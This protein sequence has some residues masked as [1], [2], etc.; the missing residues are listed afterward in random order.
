MKKIMCLLC[1]TMF[2]TCLGCGSETAATTTKKE[3]TVKTTSTAAAKDSKISDDLY[4]FEATINGKQYKIP[5]DFADFQKN[6]W[7]LDDSDNQKIEPDKY[8]LGSTLK[9]G[10]STLNVQFYNISKDTVTADKC[11]VSGILIESSDIDNG[12]KFQLPKGITNSSTKDDVIKAYG[13]PSSEEAADCEYKINEN[14]YVKF[15]F[16]D[17]KKI[18]E[19]DIVNMTIGDDNSKSDS[20]S[21]SSS[22]DSKD[23]GTSNYNAPKELGDNILSKNIKL[24]GKVYNLPVPV[25]VLEKD[26]WKLEDNGTKTL[27]SKDRQGGFDLSKGNISLSGVDLRNDSDKSTDAENCVLVGVRFDDQNGSSLELPK[28]IKIGS[29]KDEVEKAY[30]G[31]KCEKEEED[32]YT[33][34][35]YNFDDTKLNYVQ[36]NVDKSSNKVDSIEIT[37]I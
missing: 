22:N 7:K 26:G 34:Y 18:F 24:D 2:V 8:T 36:I 21:D 6:G 27:E 12:L 29:T 11:K 15:S 33:S 32:D 31:V 23:A 30:S 28:N 9:N 5:E 25:K 14:R 1:T 35:T 17:D 20:K 3:A 16:S 37:I 19:I 4:S 13:K 10:S